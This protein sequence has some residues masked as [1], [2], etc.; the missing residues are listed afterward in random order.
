M[1]ISLNNI[2]T[3]DDAQRAVDILRAVLLGAPA[4]RGCQSVDMPLVDTPVPVADTPTKPR[5]ARKTNGATP[6]A[7]PE[8][9]A[10]EPP[11]TEARSTT[12]RARSCANSQLRM[13]SPGFANCWPITAPPN[14]PT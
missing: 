4:S 1:N 14:S 10:E 13:A 3:A 2:E 12:L 9:V 8:P 7:K 6:E 5:R 11:A